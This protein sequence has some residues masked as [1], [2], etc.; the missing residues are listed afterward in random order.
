[1][2][3]NSRSGA[4][5]L[6][7]DSLLD[8][9]VQT[10]ATSHCCVIEAPAGAGKTTRI[11]PALF[12]SQLWTGET[13]VAEP[14]RIAARLMA[15]RVASEMQVPLG[16]LV[17]YSVRFDDCASQATRIRYVTS[18][19]L[20]R[21]LMTDRE[22]RGVDCVILDEFHE[23]HLDTDLCLALLSKVQE[24]RPNLRILVMSAT[25]DGARISELLGN[26]PRLTSQGRLFPLEISFDSDRDD[27]PLE[28]R[29]SSAVRHQLRTDPQG[30]I[31][32]F[33]PGAAEIRRSQA[34]ISDLCQETNIE[35]RVLHGDL[36]L[37]AQAAA[38]RSSDRPR[39]VLA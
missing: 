17:G 14:R 3:A 32:V 37:E 39:I 29:V 1:M 12:R 22:L 9:L 26:C 33:L 16:A 25:L 23:R 5:A 18:G 19:I 8:D 27:R 6:P 13:W 15:H 21:R 36:P 35:L 38:I 7:I 34:A 4:P 30:S 2:S 20:L 28:K 10:C 11:P 24:R 31:L